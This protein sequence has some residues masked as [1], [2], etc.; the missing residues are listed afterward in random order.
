[1]KARLIR[2]ARW[3]AYPAFYLFCLLAFAYLAFPYDRLRD[4]VVAEIEKRGKP[5]QRIEI[6][7]LTS[8]WLTGVRL[9]GVKLTLPTDEGPPRPKS[10]F[11]MSAP[12]DAPKESN[13]VIEDV[14]VRVRILPL[15]IGRVRVNFSAS[16]FGGEVSGS[17]PVGGSGGDVELAIEQLD[18]GQ[19]EPLVQ[20]V[21]GLPLKGTADGK[22]VLSATEGKMNKGTGSLDLTI[23]GIVIGDGK[24]KVMGIE[25]PSAKVG[26]LQISA[27]AKDKDGVMKITKLATTGPDIDVVGDGKITMRDPAVDSILDI[28][29]RF[30]FSD[31]FRG[32]NG[33]TKSLFGDPNS[34][35]PALIEMP[36]S[37]L[38]RAK[39][40]DGYYGYHGHGPLKRLRFDPSQSDGAGKRPGRTEPPAA[41]RKSPLPSGGLLPGLMKDR[42]GG[43]DKGDADG[44]GDGDKE[45]AR[46]ERERNDRERIER[47]RGERERLEKERMEKEKEREDVARRPVVPNPI[48]PLPGQDAPPVQPPDQPADPVPEQPPQ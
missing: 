11:D 48:P 21:A 6:K 16:I 27:E 14:K 38:K 24:T 30:K 18:I 42:A 26:D 4:R 39:R 34:N 43:G 23:K 25:L 15:L 40:P 44:K 3:L 12:K 10:P 9:K 28:Y 33:T 20:A 17:A 2:I 35:A 19:I 7:S 45:K 1:M 32:K 47:E 22:L 8:Y 36:P 31:A 5:G 13:I 37:E 41:G 29:L 46:V